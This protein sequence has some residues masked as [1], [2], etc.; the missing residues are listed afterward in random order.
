MLRGPT[1]DLAADRVADG[2]NPLLSAEIDALRGAVARTEL[3]NDD[4]ERYF[5]LALN[6]ASA[7][8]GSESVAV[9]RIKGL[10]A[11]TLVA[12]SRFKDAQVVAESAYALLSTQ[13]GDDHPETINALISLGAVQEQLRQDVPA[14]RN[15]R[16]AVSLIEHRFGVQDARLV[17][18]LLLLGEVL[19]RNR[20]SLRGA[21]C[22]NAEPQFRACA[23]VTAALNCPEY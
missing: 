16:S 10:S 12:L 19:R 1:L 14:L 2:S 4:A 5:E 17:K 9:G 22:S 3:R 7:A 6:Q 18:P 21:H 13:L 15:L 11:T 8:A 20:D 23:W